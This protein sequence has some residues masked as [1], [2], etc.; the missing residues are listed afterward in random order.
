MKKRE[1]KMLILQI[2]ND[3]A[4]AVYDLWRESIATNFEFL[5]ANFFKIKFVCEASY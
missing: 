4:V 3:F 1:N 5:Q 2:S